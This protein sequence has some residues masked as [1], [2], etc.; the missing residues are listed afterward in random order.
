MVTL[1]IALTIGCTR[2]QKS[3]SPHLPA[4]PPVID[5]GLMGIVRSGLE[6]LDQVDPH[7]VFV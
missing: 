4:F 6:D 3:A 2:W 5:G 7:Q 1:R